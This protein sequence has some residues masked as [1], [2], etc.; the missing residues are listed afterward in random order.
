MSR[1]LPDIY[2]TPAD[3]ERLSQLI[4]H[5]NDAASL[6]LEEELARAAVVDEANLP[7]DVVRMNSTVKFVDVNSGK[8]FEYTL[9]FPEN[10]DVAKGRISILAPIGMA[11]IGLTL[12]ETIDWPM[13]GGAT[14]SLK[15]V[16]ITTSS[17]L[18]DRTA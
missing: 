15:V 18:S 4:L 9:V 5:L 10:A 8:A 14:R 6:V 3:Y 7:F 11:L 17:A 2:I 16:S 12:H 1:A 13:P